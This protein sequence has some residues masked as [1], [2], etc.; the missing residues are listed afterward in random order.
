MFSGNSLMQETTVPHE[1]GH[2][3][4]VVETQ[5]AN[6]YGFMLMSNPSWTFWA[7][8]ITRL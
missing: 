2:V 3:T 1:G 5:D 6:W 7:C 4:F 8:E